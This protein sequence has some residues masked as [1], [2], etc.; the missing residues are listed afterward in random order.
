MNNTQVG[1]VGRSET[2]PVISVVDACVVYGATVAL[3][4]V[5]FSIHAGE[6]VGL[7]GANGAGK[8]TLISVISGG[9]KGSSGKVF[10]DGNE[11]PHWTAAS[12]ATE[13]ISVV[14]QE[15]STIDDMSIAE[16]IYLSK[17]PRIGYIVDKQRLWKQTSSLLEVLEIDRNPKTLVGDC[18][19]SE[20]RKIMIGNAL[21]R[22][23][24]VLVLDEPT[25]SMAGDDVT[26][27]LRLI[28]TLARDGVGIV[29]VSHRLRE[30][31]L[32][33]A[34]VQ[35]M[36]Q[37]RLVATVE[38][39]VTLAKLMTEMNL[40]VVS[41][42][43]EVG[44]TPRNHA[45][46]SNGWKDVVRKPK[47]SVF[48]AGTR[49]AVEQVCGTRVSGVTMELTSGEIVGVAGL[50]GCGR[51]ELL[52]LLYGV[53]MLAS[54]TIMLNDREIVG[55]PGNRVRSG[56]GYVAEGRSHNVLYD[57]S[58]GD[59]IVIT[60]L[61]KVSRCGVVN[62]KKQIFMASA[63]LEK[64]HMTLATERVLAELSGGNQ[65]KI[66]LARWLAKDARVLL[67]DEPTLGVDP[68]A[69]VEIHKIIRDLASEGLGVLVGSTEYEELMTLC[70]RIL[71][72]CEGRVTLEQTKPFVESELLRAS[73][74][75]E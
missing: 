39:P 69:R 5:S 23:P 37:G 68:L 46:A 58:V 44:E 38:R 3:D 20:K 40:G 10:I 14:P 18:S 11:R 43:G 59:N 19:P 9:V 70:D 35:I 66:L 60:N 34:R 53:Q 21:A 74:N 25:A 22:K 67:L 61:R 51:S 71:V 65:Q 49:L 57:F 2:Y 1:A 4:G 72:L 17:L 54:G 64:M 42:M 26:T 45:T 33:A 32:V 27:V 36:I 16:N 7:A 13:G 47:R 15:L 30:L 73:Y 31:E 24:R 62:R 41:E 56:I 63:I 12:A 75:V 29:F 50:A 55:G 48:G 8:S 52:R 6:V 28:S